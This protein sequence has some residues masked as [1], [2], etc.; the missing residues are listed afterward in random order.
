[1]SDSL[2]SHRVL[3]N[4]VSSFKLEEPRHGWYVALSPWYMKDVE[5]IG[6]Q[7]DLIVFPGQT[8]H[9]LTGSYYWSTAHYVVSVNRI[10]TCRRH[11][12]RIHGFRYH[13]NVGRSKV[14]WLMYWVFKVLYSRRKKCHHRSSKLW[15]WRS[16]SIAH[17]HIIMI[18]KKC[19]T[20]TRY[21][22]VFKDKRRSLVF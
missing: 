20:I 22:R 8:L 12:F 21:L 18:S 5:R 14:K 17:I 6:E 15:P 4:L 7:S 10:V 19:I 9:R 16:L 2:P 13:F 3:M 11:A 1:M